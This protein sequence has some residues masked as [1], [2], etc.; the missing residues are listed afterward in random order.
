MGAQPRPARPAGCRGAAACFR[1][2]RSLG[3][4]CPDLD[5]HR[6]WRAFGGLESGT[7]YYPASHTFWLKMGLL[8]LILLLEIW[9]MVT[10]V[11][12]RVALARGQAIDTRPAATFG[13]I[14][15]AQAALV[16]A[17]VFAATAMARGL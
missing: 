10:L 14:S 11:R 9:P 17:M 13:L 12:W 6:P 4:G 3:A 8:G 1:R 16:V 2:R 5:L 7:A 15:Y